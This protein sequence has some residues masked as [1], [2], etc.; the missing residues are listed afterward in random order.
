MEI[1]AAK[2]DRKEPKSNRELVLRDFV[3]LAW[4]ATRGL[5]TAAE[6]E[7]KTLV[8]RM[9]QAGRITEDEGAQLL[10]TLL[11]RMK[12]SREVFEDRVQASV[13]NAVEQ[14]GEIAMKEVKRLGDQISTLERRLEKLQKNR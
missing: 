3:R 1:V 4:K 9:V 12:G 10:N 5:S 8:A 6:K 14:L 11:D 2:L 7:A 13:Q